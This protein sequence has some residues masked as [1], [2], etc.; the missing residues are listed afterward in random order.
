[1]GN[2]K[3]TRQGKAEPS[4]QKD[5]ASAGRTNEDL[6]VFLYDTTLRDGSQSEDIQFTIEDK[7]R[8]ATELD[9]LGVPYIE[10]GWPGANPKD[11]EFFRRIRETP[12]SVSKMAAFGS[13]RKAHNKTSEDPV[14]QALL[15]SETPV[16]TIF[17]KS[18][19]LH[20][21]EVLNVTAS[22]NIEMIR[23]SVLFLKDHGREVVYDAEH[24]FDGFKDDPEFALNTLKAASQGGADWIILCDTNGGTLPW[25]V[26]EIFEKT[27]EVI[28]TPLGIHAHND[29]EM[30]VAN[31]LTAVRLG[32]RQVHGT[33]NGIGERCGNANLLSVMANLNLKMGI[34]TTTPSALSR[35]KHLASLLFE[36]Q[37]RSLP[38]N[39]PF[40]G[41]SAFAHKGGVH[42]HAIRKN[43]R[44][45]E[46]IEPGLVGNSQ[47]ILLSEHSGKSNLIEKARQYGITMETESPEAEKILRRL[48]ELEHQGFQF[49]GAEASFELLMRTAMGSMQPF[50]NVEF[51]H[52]L[53]D[54]QSTREAGLSE[55]TMRIKVGDLHEHTA[56]LGNGPVN[57]LDLVLR[58]SLTPFYPEVGKI[59]LVDYKVRVLTG[60]RG[61]SSGVRVLIQSS[62]DQS[63][64][65]TVGVSENVISASLMALKDS[66]DYWLFKSGVTPK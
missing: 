55:A 45:Y 2:P 54:Q 61:T 13:T 12:L 29:C 23:E 49:E 50:F 18:W 48:K 17:G 21:R 26:A 14:L 57:A 53:M 36:L 25:E 32:A 52:I 47:R 60:D 1:M 44:A 6:P 16:V 28:R 59:R 15:A 22:R 27:R 42:V 64:W 4:H 34:D 58:K 31:S 33:I 56:A 8:I 41:E 46:H 11:I 3:N 38:K 51:F 20:V 62:A 43:S 5:Q 35:L 66:I 24:Y 7:L 10:G 37:N 65:G 19:S 40:V 30:A 9:L 63:Q 39:L